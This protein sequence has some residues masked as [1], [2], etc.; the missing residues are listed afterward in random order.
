[1]NLDGEDRLETVI[2]IAF[3]LI[4]IF[5]VVLSLSY[6]A[7]RYLQPNTFP[8][9]LI[10]SDVIPFRDMNSNTITYYVD[11]RLGC[12]NIPAIVTKYDVN[13][14]LGNGKP[15]N[16]IIKASKV[17]ANGTFINKT[18]GLIIYAGLTPSTTN[19]CTSNEINKGRDFALVI[20]IEYNKTSPPSWFK[21]TT[22][23]YVILEG[24]LVNGEDW[25][26]IIYLPKDSFNVGGG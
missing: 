15:S 7:W 6:F 1:M 8:T 25:K 16:Y 26:A 14:L 3:L 2:T 11:F 24:K 5:A 19:V 13:F 18:N 9:R 22:L 10:I 4:I 23:N 12:K 17:Y 20:S 21:N